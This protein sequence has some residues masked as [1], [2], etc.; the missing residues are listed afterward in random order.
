MMH[1]FN[2]V[3]PLS[4]ACGKPNVVQ[5][6][7]CRL[8]VKNRVPCC[9]SLRPP[10]EPFESLALPSQGIGNGSRIDELRFGTLKPCGA[11]RN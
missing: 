5:F 4:T 8:C 3:H 9:F 1:S 7:L 11:T 6:D 2:S 10:E